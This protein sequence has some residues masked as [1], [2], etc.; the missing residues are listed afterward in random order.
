MIDA[1]SIR[2]KLAGI[3]AKIDIMLSGQSTLSTDIKASKSMIVGAAIGLAALIIGFFAFGV[4]ILELAAGIF[5]AGA[6]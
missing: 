4:Q 2:I 6:G 1:R 5:A 3:E